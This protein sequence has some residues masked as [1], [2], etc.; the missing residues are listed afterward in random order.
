MTDCI[1]HSEQTF[2]FIRGDK[3][4]FTGTPDSVWVFK[5]PRV[6]AVSDRKFGY[7]EVAGADCNL[8]LRAYITMVADVYP[9][10]RYY[11]LITQPRV[12]SRPVTVE[13][14]PA[15]IVK[16]R[17]EI[18]A[19]WDSSH[20]TDAPRRPS[21][22]GC[23]FC[24]A[25]AVCDEFKGWAFAVTKSEHLP[26]AQWSDATWS[27]FLTKR[28]IIEKFLKE[29]LE[30]AK[31]IKAANPDRLPEW[32]LRDGAERRIVTD[33]VGAWGKLQ[34]HMT[35]KE[36]SNACVLS[37]GDIEEIVWGKYKDNPNGRLTQRGVKALMNEA[38]AG[39]IELRRNKPSLVR[40]HE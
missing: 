15:D 21:P 31:L 29:R 34:S 2:A 27:E 5:K 35:A 28:P 37:I 24:T 26:S 33:I 32:E 8:Q 1:H 10:E 9:A 39:L 3:V 20:A 38:L 19:V 17:A 12:S 14:T 16:A 6:V 13:Y 30:D 22:D 25:Q 23:Q 18:E 4:L 40:A 36:F 7:K 11:G